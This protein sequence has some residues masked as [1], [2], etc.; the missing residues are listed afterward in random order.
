MFTVL[1]YGVFFF[2]LVCVLFINV[3]SYDFKSKWTLMKRQNLGALVYLFFVFFFGSKPARSPP[4]TLLQT[5]GFYS[6]F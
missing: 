5:I 1:G 4:G 2:W 6:V 3:V